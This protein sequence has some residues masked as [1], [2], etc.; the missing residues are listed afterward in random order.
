MIR[1]AIIPERLAR[2][3]YFP[4]KDLATRNV[5]RR[6]YARDRI[7]GCISR[8]PTLTITHEMSRTSVPGS[9]RSISCK[10]AACGPERTSPE[11][12]GPPPHPEEENRKSPKH[13]GRVPRALL[14]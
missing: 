11:R 13:P 2:T 1:P 5:G 7:I 10:Q 9:R 12:R 3:R 6:K 4:N 14:V 8:L